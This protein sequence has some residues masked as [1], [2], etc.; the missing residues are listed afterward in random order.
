MIYQAVK[1][2]T[3][4]EAEDAVVNLFETAGAK[5]TMV[6]G[7]E[8]LSAIKDDKTINYVD[9]ALLAMPSDEVM[10]TGFFPK[11]GRFD[12][13]LAKLKD[14][15]AALRSFGLDPGR[16]RFDVWEIAEEDWANSWKQYYKP[17]K[18]GARVVVK[19]TWEAYTPAPGETMIEMDPG[20]A[21][22]TGTHETT[23]LCV[24]ALE[25]Q[26]AG[27]E[28]VYDIGCGSGILSI[29]AA[30]LGAGDVIGVDF[31][32]VAVDA[33]KQ[34]VALNH[35][36]D[37]IKI[38]EGDLLD[39]VPRENPADIIV[40]NILA[41]VVIRLIDSVRLYL[42]DGG[43]FIASGII[44]EHLQEVIDALKVKQFDNIDVKTMGEW[45]AVIARKRP[46]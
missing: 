34:N 42:K 24:R 31:D 6:E 40:A 13:A 38:D 27:G 23:R 41:E 1:I 12:A 10:I 22:G 7:A 30:K 18:I 37:Q 32:P 4:P 8:N 26:I 33:A 46:E 17:T 44:H 43:V 5:G 25:E 15:V 36:S 14:G 35:L 39:V 9:E 29:A 19:P 21:F 2:T 11:D 16:A 28:R 45:D 20:M 3:T